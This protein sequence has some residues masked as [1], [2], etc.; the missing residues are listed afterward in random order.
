MS[1]L[2][3]LCLSPRDGRGTAFIAQY[4]ACT[5]HEQQKTGLFLVSNHHV[6]IGSAE[7]ASVCINNSE[8]V[9]RPSQAQITIKLAEIASN[10][11]SLFN[12]KVTANYY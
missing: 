8:I 1:Y 6:M 3:I 11:G 5:D 7:D 9:F 12:D 2:C 4:T 10:R